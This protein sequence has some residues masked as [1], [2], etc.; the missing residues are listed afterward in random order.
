MVYKQMV[1]AGCHALELTW[2]GA[3]QRLVQLPLGNAR[4]ERLEEHPHADGHQG[5]QDAIEDCVEHTD[6]RCNN[7]D[8]NWR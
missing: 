8:N 4:I 5:G 6:F 1:Y 3:D 2:V 7:L